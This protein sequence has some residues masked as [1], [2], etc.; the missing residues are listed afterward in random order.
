MSH[1]VKNGS[2]LGNVTTADITKPNHSPTPLTGLFIAVGIMGLW[3]GTLALVLS[4]SINHLSLPSLVTVIFL[5]MFLHT[6][7][8]I[9]A[10]DS[11]HCSIIPQNKRLNLLIGQMAVALYACLPYGRCSLNHQKHHLM[12]GQAG[13]PDFHNGMNTHLVRWYFKFIGEYVSVGQLLIFT[14][15]STGAG[16]ILHFGFRV[17]WLNL[18]L[19]WGTPLILSS[20]QLFY[21]GTYLP[22]REIPAP[23]SSLHAD[24]DPQ[25]I[26]D[27]SANPSLWL[28]SFLC[29]Y[30]F[31]T[32][33]P[34]HH[35][36]PDIPWYQLPNIQDANPPGHQIISRSENLL[37]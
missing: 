36:F 29:C 9:T 14:S 1:V 34:Q 18:L 31:G 28:A 15:F 26:H 17:A 25:R 37:N 32:F 21:F 8:F 27:R 33:H 20:M 13:D 12:P 24:S 19:F 23:S 5:R 30:H 7:L 6:G 35:Q 16:L 11:M 4:I 2:S 10:H 22:H 3:L